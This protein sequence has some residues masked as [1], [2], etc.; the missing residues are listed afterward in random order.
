MG[1]E[2]TNSGTSSIMTEKDAEI[3]RLKEKIE[4]VKAIWSRRRRSYATWLKDERKKRSSLVLPERLKEKELGR[5]QN[6][7]FLENV[8]RASDASAKPFPAFSAGALV[9]LLKFFPAE[10]E[11][12]TLPRARLLAMLSKQFAAAAAILRASPLTGSCPHCKH[13]G[14]S[15]MQLRFHIATFHEA[16][17]SALPPWATGKPGEAWAWE[18]VSMPE[19]EYN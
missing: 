4:R 6:K 11:N 5:L 14:F 16:S 18:A 10:A 3:D 19:L 9:R 15:A 17:T 13:W 1:C 12:F 2:M 7:L 8:E